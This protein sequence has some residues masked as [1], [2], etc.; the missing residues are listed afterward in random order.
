MLWLVVLQ[1]LNMVGGIRN[2]L[3]AST[4][5][6]PAVVPAAETRQEA[7]RPHRTAG[8][9]AGV[10]APRHDGHRGGRGK[11]RPRVLGI[12]V[13]GLCKVLTDVC[14]RSVWPSPV[15]W[16]KPDCLKRWRR[17][18][19]SA[20]SVGAADPVQDGAGYPGPRT[21]KYPRQTGVDGGAS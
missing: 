8:T 17:R 6:W 10:P 14:W 3:S 1:H 11:A 15:P 7:F 2:M 12:R 5:G 21:R 13:M 18:D 20:D 4:S 16:P 9:R 19:G